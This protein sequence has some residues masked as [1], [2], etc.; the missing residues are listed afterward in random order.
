MLISRIQ[1]DLRNKMPPQKRYN[2]KTKKMGLSK[3]RKWFF[4]F[5]FLNSPHRRA[6]FKIFQYINQQ[7]IET[8]QNKGNAFSK[9]VLDIFCRSKTT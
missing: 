6:F 5:N 8:Q 9:T 3:S 4:N 1:A 7:K 2:L